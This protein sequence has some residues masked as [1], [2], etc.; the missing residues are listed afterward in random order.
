MEGAPRFRSPCWS[1]GSPGARARSGGLIVCSFGGDGKDLPRSHPPPI[2]RECKG[3]ATVFTPIPGRRPELECTCFQLLHHRLCVRLS[4][5]LSSCL[6]L[7]FHLKAAEGESNWLCFLAFNNESRQRVCGE[8]VTSFNVM[9]EIK[10]DGGVL[11]VASCVT[12]TL[13]LKTDRSP[14][15]QTFARMSRGGQR[16]CSHPRTPGPGSRPCRKGSELQ[17]VTLRAPLPGRLP[18]TRVSSEAQAYSTA[19]HHQRSQAAPGRM[20]YTRSERNGR[21]IRTPSRRPNLRC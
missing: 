16:P 14:E 9:K 18:M 20:G 2:P 12:E 5:P 8:G 21:V 6:V 11:P 4:V 19:S 15:T 10:P 3:D 1:S 7:G 13:G 17:T